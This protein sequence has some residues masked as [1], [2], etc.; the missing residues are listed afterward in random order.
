M[1]SLRTRFVNTR[2]AGRVRAKTGSIARVNTL[3][4]YIDRADGKVYTFSVQANHHA[5]PS[6]RSSRRS[7]ASWWRWG[8][9]FGAR[10]LARVSRDRS[11]RSLAP[12]G[13]K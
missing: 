10:D 11:R 12:L 2:L 7:T 5:L 4:G 8:G 6:R 1:G 9:R 13:M 3:S